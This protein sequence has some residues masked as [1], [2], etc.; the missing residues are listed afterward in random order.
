LLMCLN[1]IHCGRITVA[2]TYPTLGKVTNLSGL[3]PTYT[4]K[5]F[6][7]KI[8][9]V[10]IEN[11]RNLR[12]VDIE[13][14]NIVTI[15][16]ENNSGK[17]NFLRAISLP[18]TSDDTGTNKRLSW[19]DINI[20]AKN[21]YYDFLK[22]K[23]ESIID[24]TITIEQFQ[25]HIPFVSIV[26]F[27]QPEKNEHYNVRNIRC[28]EDMHFG[29]ISYR[30]YIKNPNELL[31]RAK[32]ILIAETNDN[33]IQMSLLPMELY[34]YSL[35]VPGKGCKISYDTISMFR[36]VCLSAER[37]T[38]AS[39]ANKLG[40]KALSDL[41]QKK[42]TPES[43]AVIEKK[44]RDF[45]NTVRNEGKLDTVLNWQAYSE[46]SNAKEFFQEISILPNMPQMNSILGSIRLGYENE[47][48]FQ[49]GLGH[50]NLVLMS[51]ILS[52]YIERKREISFRLMT[53]EEPE[54]HLC[55]SNILLMIS[56][57]NIFS[58]SNKFTQIVYS[59][60]NSEFVN[61][62]GLEKVI[63]F[64]N[65]FAYN[66]GKELEKEE[67]D[68]LTA[69]PNTDIF[70]LLYSRKVILVEGITEELLIRSYL[71]TQPTLNDIKVLS[72]H[73]GF[74]KI[75]DIW[76]GINTGTSNKL[77]IVRDYDDQPKAQKNHEKRQNKQIIVR[78]TEGYTLE[79][80]ITRNNY[81]LL[82]EKYGMEYGWSDMTEEEIQA[83]WRKNKSYVMLRICH[84][85]ISGKL[86]DFV[87]PSHIQQ[88]I[89]FL[90]ENTH[91][92]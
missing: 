84:D 50:R 77:G 32:T 55:N 64:H 56:L 51:V 92:S 46:I 4:R 73:K 91:G 20:E 62:I 61:K 54:A 7:M 5:V 58:K 80:D 12:K 45:F 39:N 59:T 90:Q 78:T 27:F 40:S 88:V 10:Q 71:Q 87:M 34:T 41:L 13:L 49:Q 11:Y 31:N 69:N 28:D 63:L 79:T 89:D 86:S 48:M 44:Y 8:R 76:K 67:R 42:L 16:G 81:T 66:L 19:Y 30:Y 1:N 68:Y 83:D 35:T 43:Q 23:R 25:K 15:I 85:M 52:S 70:K 38:F 47:A 74:T 26:L 33:N 2:C 37:D 60:H 75:I 65:G 82:K 14:E 17:S 9:R 6:K 57:F 53:V 22:T 3:Y 24:G 36:T 21:Q 29:G 72:F 18:L